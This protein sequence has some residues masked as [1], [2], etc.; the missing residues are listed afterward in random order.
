MTGSSPGGVPVRWKSAA[1]L[2]A[3]TLF[4]AA[5]AAQK[6]ANPAPA[7]ADS[8]LPAV[9]PPGRPAI[10]VALEGGGALGLAHIGVLQWLEEHH[11]P[12]DRI[13][14]TS[15]G[16]LVGA[17]YATGSTPAQMRELAVSDAFTRV[18][19]LQTPYA[20]A[21]FR[22]RQDR[23]ELPQALT[24]GLRHRITLRNALFTDRGVNELL[25]GNL[26]NYNSQELDYDR[27]PIPFRCVATDLNTL[28]PVTF[29]SGPLPQAVRASIS[30]PG[31]FSP[32]QDRNGHY[33]VDGGIL[34][35][36]PT[37][38]LKRDL[39]ADIII[40][41]H[42]EDSALS[43]SDTS[44]I[45]GVLHRAFDAGIQHNVTE[46]ERL[47]D[48]VINVPIGSFS[49]TDYAHAVALIDA[50]YK[51]AEQNRAALLR[52]ALDADGWKAYLAARE[53]RRSPQPGILLQVRVEGA[54][55]E[56]SA[57]LAAT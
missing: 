20:D 41:I 16:A 39:H 46:S 40:A 35:S 34:D 44:S 7:S 4:L 48:V 37:D 45:L 55:R 3:A 30:I 21:S 38:V 52:Y 27:L 17:F 31:V 14:G 19:T 32:V 15:M 54:R 22:R 13:S 33:L 29:A 11:I 2:L 5:A 49:P 26:P 57:R 6:P 43:T 28:A 10:G 53:S 36:L 47:A 12:V 1:I 23:H 50:G 24:I 8:A 25:T 18:F 56:P 51:A 42:L 9:Q